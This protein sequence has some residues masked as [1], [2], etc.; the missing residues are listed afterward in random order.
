MR[1]SDWSSDVC[2]SDLSAGIGNYNY[3]E[4]NAALNVPL[5]DTLAVRGA[6]QFTKHDGY[7]YATKVPGDAKYDLDDED[8]TGWRLGAKWSPSSNFSLTLNTIQYD[9]NTHGDR[10][11]TRLT[12]VTNA[13][14][15]CRL[16][17][18][19]KKKTKQHIKSTTHEQHKKKK[20]HTI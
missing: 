5:S 18:E 13:H 6:F 10:K 3:K 20:Q 2:S 4:G 19:K 1:I 11:S 8:N 15:V 9:S 17:L 12:P 14:L 7:S 16:L